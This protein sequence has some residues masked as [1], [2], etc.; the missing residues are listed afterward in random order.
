MAIEIILLKDSTIY[1][2]KGCKVLKT[3]WNDQQITSKTI[4]RQGRCWRLFQWFWLK[5]R[6]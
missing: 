2:K 6:T 4:E 5:I 3:N 1:Y